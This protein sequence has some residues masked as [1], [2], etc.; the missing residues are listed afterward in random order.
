MR[1]AMS[2][3]V[4]TL[5]EWYW[6]MRRDTNSRVPIF[7]FDATL[8]SQDVGTANVGVAPGVGKPGTP[9]QHAAGGVCWSF[10]EG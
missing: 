6:T 3:L 2:S 10:T 8:G 7:G 5:S 9:S 4:K 1:E